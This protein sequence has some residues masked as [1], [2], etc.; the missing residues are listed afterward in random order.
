MRPC[1]VTASDANAGGRNAWIAGRTVFDDLKHNP[2]NPF[3]TRPVPL[4]PQY[5]THARPIPTGLL[6][7]AHFARPRSRDTHRTN[8]LHTWQLST[9]RQFRPKGCRLPWTNALCPSQLE[10]PA[11]FFFV[12]FTTAT[13]PRGKET[14]TTATAAAEPG[15]YTVHDRL[16]WMDPRWPRIRLLLG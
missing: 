14:A 15:N 13:P 11:P 12:L 16:V 9:Q 1:D 8:R 6:F 7:L 4:H 5:P 3:G 2:T 10:P